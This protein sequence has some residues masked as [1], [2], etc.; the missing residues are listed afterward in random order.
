M[1]R[2]TRIFTDKTLVFPFV[3]GFFISVGLMFSLLTAR[4]I[5][6]ARNYEV[7]SNAEEY[8]CT[9][10]L[11]ICNI[12]LFVIC[13]LARVLTIFSTKNWHEGFEDELTISTLGLVNLWISAILL[14]AALTTAG[15]LL[16]ITANCFY[17]N[18]CVAQPDVEQSSYM[19]V[20]V[21]V[22]LWPSAIGFCLEWLDLTII[23]YRRW[24]VKNFNATHRDGIPLGAMPARST[25]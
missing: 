14:F 19:M 24:R 3:L 11:L 25:V 12:S 17:R 22:G 21:L 6:S 10:Y 23:L 4:G 5:L 8:L 18:W 7:L 1:A 2:R 20:I 13:Y 9:L 15:V 16:S